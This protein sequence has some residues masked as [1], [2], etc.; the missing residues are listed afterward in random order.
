MRYFWLEHSSGDLPQWVPL[1]ADQVAALGFTLIYTVPPDAWYVRNVYEH[2]P[3]TT[4]GGFKVANAFSGRWFIDADKWAAIGKAIIAYRDLRVSWFRRWTSFLLGPPAWPVVLLE[5]ETY[6]EQLFAYCRDLSTA[7]NYDELEARF[8]ELPGGVDYWFY[9]IAKLPQDQALWLREIAKRFQKAHPS[10]RFVDA[11]DHAP[12]PL[13]LFDGAARFTAQTLAKA[14]LRGRHM[15][16]IN[17][18]WPGDGWP[19]AKVSKQCGADTI[20]YPGSSEPN[21]AAMLDQLEQE[22]PSG[23]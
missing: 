7:P 11:E 21:V 16:Y 22:N 4:I 3:E 8:R 10:A 19:R 20:L 5:F 1:A 15:R 2:L 23:L 18:V 17:E 13:T 12:R 9:P 14:G 6:F